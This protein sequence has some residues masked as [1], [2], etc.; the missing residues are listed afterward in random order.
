LFLIR[1]ANTPSEAETIGEIAVAAKRASRRISKAT[2]VERSR[3][4][5]LIAETLTSQT[6]AILAANRKDL[7]RATE[8]SAAM[9]DRLMLDEKR[10][11]KMAHAVR[12]IAAADDPV[13]EVVKQW[14]RPNGLRVARRRIPLGVIAIIYEAR[15]NVTSDA[16]AL[17]LRAGNAVILR[18]GS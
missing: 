9:R 3:A 15:P 1:E 6:P 11:A 2:G 12:Q 4:L 17:C 8:L 18:G 5:E 7:G 14:T 13:G 16:A 10:V